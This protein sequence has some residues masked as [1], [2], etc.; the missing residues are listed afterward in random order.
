M[1]TGDGGC[2]GW[3]VAWR[4]VARVLVGAG[5]MQ[6][7]LAGALPVL[8]ISALQLENYLDEAKSVMVCFFFCS[9]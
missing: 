2:G 6:N 3:Q 9:F 5:N 1:Q 8:A 4:H 7:R